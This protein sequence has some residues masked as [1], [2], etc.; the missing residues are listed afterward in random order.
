MKTKRWVEAKKFS[1]DGDDWGD[2]EYGEYDHDEEELPP[3]PPVP[4][5]NPVL[6]AGQTNATSGPISNTPVRPYGFDRSVTTDTLGSVDRPSHADRS[7]TFDVTSSGGFGNGRA[8]PFV[9]PADIYKRMREE[10]QRQGTPQGSSPSS[11]LPRPTDTTSKTGPRLPPRVPE[12]QGGFVTSPVAEGR[13]ARE[14]KPGQ[15]FTPSSVTQDGE[16]PKLPEIKRLSTGFLG[17]EHT[18]SRSPVQESPHGDSPHSREPDIPQESALRH[19]SSLGFRSAVNQAFDAPETP[20][21]ITDDSLVRSNSD[22]TSVMSP[23]ISSRAPDGDKTPTIAEEPSEVPTSGAPV[24]KPGHRRDL[25]LPSSDNSPSKRPDVHETDSIPHPKLAEL[26]SVSQLNPSQDGHQNYESE[27]SRDASP[28]RGQYQPLPLRLGQPSLSNHQ[29]LADDLPAIVPQLS[30][31]T[32]PQDTESDRLR[33]EIILSLSRENSPGRDLGPQVHES[34][35]EAF[36]GD[37]LAPNDTSRLNDYQ[38]ESPSD[39]LGQQGQSAG[40][41]Y[42]SAVSANLASTTDVSS[43]ADAFNQDSQPKRSRRFSWESSDSDVSESPDPHQLL[44]QPEAMVQPYQIHRGDTFDTD[45][46]E[47][48]IQKSEDYGLQAETSIQKSEDYDPR[49]GSEGS[50]PLA[51]DSHD[52]VSCRDLPIPIANELSSP[53][54]PDESARTQQVQFPSAPNQP[55]LAFREI[56]GIRSSQ[57]RIRAFDR[58]RYQFASIDTGLGDW[59]E[60]TILAHPEY[61]EI[62]EQNQEFTNNHNMLPSKAK[63][64]K[65]TSLGNLASHLDGPGSIKRQSAQLGSQRRGKEILHS[66]GLLGGKAGGAARGLFAKGRSKLRSDKVEP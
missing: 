47:T 64:P 62:V 39:N 22:S 17:T 28:Q 30:V 48:S 59:I 23:I 14:Y 58:T 38:V 1:Y 18:I 43:P 21:I 20:S 55:L 19:N 34:Q 35:T 16:A 27:T 8:V 45:I 26:S 31:E 50:V 13:D 24:F 36:H 25:S 12:Q 41:D 53:D 2:D 65:L 40:H 63:F 37:N 11:G 6:V 60:A 5:V 44:N 4:P 52:N 42:F 7:Q 10:R 57:E 33:K 46:S 32:S 15:S 61:S 56:L 54:L 66:A 29:S 3:V 51:E 9:R 49:P